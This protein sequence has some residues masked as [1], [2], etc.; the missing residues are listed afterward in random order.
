M[1]SK[2][3]MR[4]PKWPLLKALQKIDGFVSF[5]APG[6]LRIKAKAKLCALN[7]GPAD[8]LS[9]SINTKLSDD[10][11]A[12]V[13]PNP[14]ATAKEQILLHPAGML[15]QGLMDKLLDRGTPSDE[16]ELALAHHYKQLGVKRLSEKSRGMAVSLLAYTASKRHWA[17]PA[18]GRALRVRAKLQRA[19]GQ[20]NGRVPL[21]DDHVPR[22][23]GWLD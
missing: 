10:A 22:V 15:T 13:T 20:H 7:A 19:L 14:T 6:A 3:R 18:S 21:L 23:C 5:D 1:T 17:I 11:S 16:A 9:L 8:V 12:T 2:M 4:T